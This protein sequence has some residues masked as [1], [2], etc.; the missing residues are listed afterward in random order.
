MARELQLSAT[1]I[2]EMKTE[3]LGTSGLD[4]NKTE[5]LDQMFGELLGL[6]P[7]EFQEKLVSGLSDLS[8]KEVLKVLAKASEYLAYLPGFKKMIIEMLVKA[9]NDLIDVDDLTEEQEAAIIRAVI[10]ILI[11]IFL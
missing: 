8:L 2:N 6:S 1:K 4:S 3:M 5:K 11:S 7:A 9:I 10:T